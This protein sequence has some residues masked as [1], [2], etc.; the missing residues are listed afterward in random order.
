[1]STRRSGRSAEGKNCC[2]TKPMPTRDA[3]SSA[4]QRPTVNQRPR[5]AI[6]SSREKTRAT[7]PLRPAWCFIRRGCSVTRMCGANS[8]A[9]TQDTIS[10]A[11]IT[12][13]SE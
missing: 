12:T 1:M 6:T 5:M 2:C 4:A 3:T 9:T 7:M 10:E 13:K 8:T 11:A